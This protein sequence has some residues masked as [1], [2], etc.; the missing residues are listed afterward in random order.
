M[1]MMRALPLAVSAATRDVRGIYRRAKRNVVL[2]AVAGVCFV[3]AYV[4]LMISAGVYL[5]TI[6]GPVAAALIIAAGMALLG[7]LIM[8]AMAFMK[9]R[10]RRRNS[11]RR[12]GQK[13]AAA[14]AISVL[15]QLT[16]SKGLLALAAVGGLAYFLTQGNGN[17]DE[18]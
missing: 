14:A 11:R 17:D 5:A 7:G 6:Y 13:L 18:V 12:A 10:E 2:T 16:K 8:A 15:P 4:A 3:T 9:I 1:M